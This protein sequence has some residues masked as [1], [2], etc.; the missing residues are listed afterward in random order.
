MTCRSA[1]RAVPAILL[2]AA[3]QLATAPAASAQGGGAD[4]ELSASPAALPADRVSTVTVTGRDY[5]VPPHAE[6]VDVFGGVYVFFGWVAD[7][8]RFGPSIRNSNDND[9]T[10][11][12]TYAYPGGAGDASTRDDGSGAVRL[13]SFTAGGESGQATDFHMDGDG[14]WTTTVQVF[15]STFTATMP[16]GETRTYDCQEV[17]CGVFTVGAHGIASATNEKFAPVTFETETGAASAPAD[18]P[19]GPTPAGSAG[20]AAAVTGSAATTPDLAPGATSSEGPLDLNA[21]AVRSTGG[22]GPVVAAAAAAGLVA[23]ALGVAWLWRRRRRAAPEDD[24]GTGPGEQFP[25]PE[26]GTSP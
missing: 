20:P 16:D 4:P 26:G 1:L 10:F 23:A 3:L 15:G 8:D 22:I 6:G 9:G 7:P 25:T 13:V 19:G 5:L 18:A 21:G 14:N 2:A 24:P 11:G 17:Q 12:V